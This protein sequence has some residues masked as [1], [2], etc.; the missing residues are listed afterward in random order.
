MD[1]SNLTV[2]GSFVS[3]V[4]DILRTV[5]F[6]L[7][8]IVYGLASLTFSVVYKLYDL[9]SIIDADDLLS[10][11]K[12]TIYSF[13]AIFMFFKISFSLLE[14]LVDP[15]KIEDK[16]K[17]AGKLIA[18]VI[19]TLALIVVVPLGFKYAKIVQTKVIQEQLIEKVIYGSDFN[20]IGSGNLT[21]GAKNYDLGD[22]LS[23]SVWSVFLSPTVE[24]GQAYD[25]YEELFGDVTNSK[26]E[27]WNLFVHLNDTGNSP[28]NGSL[29]N[30]LFQG[31]DKVV[32]VIT[33]N[34]LRY[35]IG[36]IYIVSNIMGLYLLWIIIKFC[37]DVAYRSIKFLALEMLSP[38]AVISYIDPKSSKDGIFA[39]WLGQTVK[40]YLSL[41]IRIFVLAIA[42][43]LLYKLNTASIKGG[44][45][46][47]LMYILAI[48]AFIKTAPKFI[49][50]IFG[51]TL[52]KDNET[53]FA[54]DL[55]KGAF[56]GIAGAAVGG[57]SGAVV[58]KRTG[59]PVFKNVMK[60]GWKAGKKGW[61]SGKKGN[62]L[63]MASI[64]FESYA[65]AKKDMGYNV[66]KDKNKAID[67]LKE[68]VPKVDTAKSSA[69]R[70]ILAGGFEK[71]CNSGASVNGRSYGS[72]LTKDARAKNAI[73]KNAAGLAQA[74][75]LHGDDSEY[76]K[77]RN[78]VADKDKTSTLTSITYDN[79]L[80]QYNMNKSN[81]A[82]ADE[83]SKV[84]YIGD[85]AMEN[86]KYSCTKM[87]DTTRQQHFESVLANYVDKNS[88]EYKDQVIQFK[89]S[90]KNTQ[91]QMSC[92]VVRNN[93]I[94]EASIMNSVQKDAN[95]EAL[96]TTNISLSYDHSLGDMKSDSDKAKSDLENAKKALDNYKK[97]NKKAADIDDNYDMADSLYKAENIK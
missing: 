68:M 1:F 63:G 48:L 80:D 32:K 8:I 50:D 15:T 60:Q 81:Y 13:L 79:A 96:N 83:A 30:T 89:N 33:F 91:I 58:A 6:W 70:E 34:E 61:E 14:M 55:L 39:K 77:L 75:V 18:N 82:A 4:S 42:S 22:R 25:A 93:A 21:N 84:K 71:V 27:C 43:L 90:D 41:F 12:Q 88:G 2:M 26:W 49:D 23:L 35:N 76:M 31:V 56:G 65:G 53:K 40:T 92:E 52:S 47:I 37:I 45:I 51:T 20:K 94:K 36:Y 54:S 62:L 97:Q 9:S 38:I 72:K 59:T 74:R 64:P 67:R 46:V 29:L 95:F 57:I 44:P 28:F 7:D 19:I 69:S 5:S 86:I 17:G 87:D 73:T 3:I 85:M 78:H 66:D 10:T 24:S 11:M 16:Q